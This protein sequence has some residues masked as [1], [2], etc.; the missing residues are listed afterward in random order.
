MIFR[1]SRK[2]LNALILLTLLSLGSIS[3][4]GSNEELRLAELSRKKDFS[5]IAEFSKSKLKKIASFDDG[6]LYYVALS[7][8]QSLD[9]KDDCASEADQAKTELAKKLLTYGAKYYNKPYKKPCEKLYFDIAN[10]DEKIAFLQAKRLDLLA[11]LANLRNARDVKRIASTETDNNIVSFELKDLD[12]KLDGLYLE[13]DEAEKMS[14]SL[15]DFCTKNK[16]SSDEADALYKKLF[17]RNSNSADADNAKRC[18]V[19]QRISL[20]RIFCIKRNYNVSAQLVLDIIHDV[21]LDK[22]SKNVSLILSRPVLSDFGRAI[23]FGSKEYTA[24]LETFKTL[25]AKL[26]SEHINPISQEKKEIL[27]T[28][29][30]YIARLS[31]NVQPVSKRDVLTYYDFAINFAPSDKDYDN[32]LWYKLRFLLQDK[33]TDDD[34]YL[35][36]IKKASSQWKNAHLYEDLISKLSLKYAQTKNATKLRKLLEI[37]APTDLDEEKAKLNYIIGR[38]LGSNS[39]IQNAY[40][41]KHDNFYYK[42]M[43][44][45]HLGV[46]ADFAFE[47]QFGRSKEL[48]SEE[49]FTLI[50]GLLRFGLENLVYQHIK[51]FAQNISVNDA[52]SI[53]TRLYEKGFYSESVQSIRYALRSKNAHFSKKSLELLYP[54]AFSSF[55]TKYASEYAIPEYFIYSLIRCESFFRTSVASHAG[56]IG[57]C[58]LMPNTA[59]EIARQLKIDNYDIQDPETNIRFGAFYL[60][61][62]LRSHKVYVKAFQAYNA[63][64]ATVRRWN[65]KYGDLG[66]DLFVETIAFPETRNYTKRVLETACHYAEIYYDIPAKT[67]IQQFFGF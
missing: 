10:K 61:R 2:K 67:L 54:R 35:E 28:V 22:N 55:V 30:F 12:R 23:L 34:T 1:Q 64:S 13:N 17:E 49:C 60:S 14:I 5:Q 50:N 36:Y 32:A 20:A 15:E 19:F 3:C 52:E 42:V 53:S 9:N 44:A 57:L 4:S 51:D 43:A 29:S 45:Y 27:H 7:I 48:S 21:F 38:L 18:T 25:Y 37:I 33:S 41:A 62:M 47:Q 58:Q 24:S 46:K 65:R 8:M 11:D 59:K 40:Y 6:S 16:L 26:A 66:A 56:A 39:E 63:G 31:E